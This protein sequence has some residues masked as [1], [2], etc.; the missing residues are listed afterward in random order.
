[1]APRFGT[2]GVR[3]VANAEITPEYV[4]LLGRAAA[5]ILGNERWIVG[6]DT[7]VSGTLLQAALAAGLA[8]EGASVELIG[9]I[10]TPGVAFVSRADSVPAAVLSASHNPYGDNGIKL[11][12]PGGRKLADEVEARLEAELDTLLAGER[13]PHEIPVGDRVGRIAERPD[14]TA[15]YVEAL[16]ATLEGRRLD[17]MHVVVDAANGAA[18]Q[19]GPSLLRNLG[20]RVEVIHAEPDGRNINDGCGSLHPQS[21]QTAVV[22]AGADAGLAFDGDAD[23]VLAVDATGAL[24]DGDQIIGA[25]AVDLDERGLLAGHAVVVTVMANLGLRTAM[26]QR[27]IRVVET[28][29][30]DRYVL[31]ALEAGGYTLGGEQSGHVIY[32]DLFSGL[33]PTGD[34]V[35][36]GVLLLDLMARRGRPLAELASVMERLPQVLVSVRVA[37][38]AADVVARMA[39][40]LAAA[41]AELAG[42]GRVLVRASGT[43]PLVRVMVEAPSAAQAES[44][45]HRLAG[46]AER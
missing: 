16:T 17:G 45:A 6:R 37:S 29:V 41:T 32:R 39:P 33:A 40:E 34:G 9:V 43:E 38:N 25:S 2:D 28:P 22:A 7:R 44:V 24:V 31:D 18:H 36:T 42:T 1:M 3:G 19:V 12:A 46:L 20:A 10:P 26:A 4:M 30:G 27:G 21:L 35:L 23:R 14:E 11:F 13:A 15:R 5:R 8:A